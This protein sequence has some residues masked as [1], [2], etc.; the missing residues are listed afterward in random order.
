M[1]RTD[2]CRPTSAGPGRHPRPSWGEPYDAPLARG[3]AAIDDAVVQ[4]AAPSLPELDRLGLHAITAP[5]RRPARIGALLALGLVPSRLEPVTTR[6]LGALGRRPG[7]M[8]G[9]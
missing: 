5:V 9:A 3:D 1:K 7:A 6:D 8:A 4:A 2:C